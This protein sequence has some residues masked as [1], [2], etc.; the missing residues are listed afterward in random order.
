MGLGRGGG[1]M[2]RDMLVGKFLLS[3]QAFRYVF[4]GGMTL[5]PLDV[6]AVSTAVKNGVFN[7]LVD[8]TILKQVPRLD[9]RPVHPG[10][11]ELNMLDYRCVV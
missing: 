5:D 10:E 2:V 11:D 4:A 7:E 6:E 8:I 3:D 9:S 1:V